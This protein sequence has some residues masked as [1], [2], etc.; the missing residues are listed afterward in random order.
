M[1]TMNKMISNDAVIINQTKFFKPECAEYVREKVIKQIREDGVAM[2]PFGFTAL[3][4]D[5]T[6]VY[7][8]E[9]NEN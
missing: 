6:L 3:I 1:K 7:M 2:V 5:R 8:E 4:A 9:K